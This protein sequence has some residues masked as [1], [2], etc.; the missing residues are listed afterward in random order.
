MRLSTRARYTLRM[1]VTIAR[2]TKEGKAISLNDVSEATRISRR[3]LEQ[4][5]IVLKNA[6]LIRGRTGKRGGYL[7]T[8]SPEKIRI[9]QIIEA[10]IGPINIV[11]CV[12]QP[13]M[14]LESDL[15]ECRPVY[16]T[17]NER[18]INALDDLTLNDLVD[19]PQRQN[20]SWDLAIDGSGCPTRKGGF[21]GPLLGE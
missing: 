15:C 4:L 18:I 20:L 1:M 5:A 14:C 9:G 21:V 6:S 3:Y 16:Q 10:A 19:R 8:R 13:E 11:D 7:L 17:I 12:R 2:R